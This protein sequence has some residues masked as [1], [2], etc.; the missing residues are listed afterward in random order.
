MDAYGTARLAAKE[1]QSAI[2]ARICEDFNLTPVLARAHYEQMARSF[3]DYGQVATEPGELCYLAVDANEPSGKPI[4]ACRKVQVRLEL[5]AVEDQGVLRDSGL[6]AMRQQ[7]L[8]R[9]ARQAQVQ[10]GLLTVEDLAYLTC[11]SPAT[12][13]R[14]L[15]A[16]R[17]RD[18]AVP[19]RG[20]IKDIG[21]GLSHKALVVE[22]YLWGLQFTDIESRTRH[23]E[24]S[25]KR[26]LAD[27]R[28]IAALY[29]RGAKIPEIRAATGRSAALIAE[30]IGL[31]ERARREFP[32]APRLY[33]LLDVHRARTKK[34]GRR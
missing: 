20:Q 4:L 31:Y 18:V 33:E 6:A 27:F 21:P 25:I 19:T 9:L 12:V 11:S 22:L 28:Q 16:C 13:K 5:A 7:R 8:A 17:R 34:G 10:G 1:A 15:A 26:Y 2:V 30:Y 29:A 24:A 3:A 23:S 32:A 14:D